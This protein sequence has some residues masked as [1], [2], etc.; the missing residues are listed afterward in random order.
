MAAKRMKDYLPNLSAS[1]PDYY[2]TVLAVPA[3]NVLTEQWSKE[4][5]ILAADS[6]G[7]QR[8]DLGDRTAKVV[9]QFPSLTDSDAGTILDFWADPAK[10]NGKIR[11]F[12]WQAPEPYQNPPSDNGI[13]V[14]RFDEDPSRT[15]N[16]AWIFGI[17]SVTL[18]VFGWYD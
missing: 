2:A 6:G 18:K 11:T 9:L 7:E 8:L 4:V 17:A 16:A 5:E 1:P 13:Y 15:M 14:V 12:L 10:A 3:Q